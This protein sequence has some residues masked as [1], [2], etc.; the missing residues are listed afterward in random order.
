MSIESV[1]KQI[2][3]RNDITAFDKQ[4]YNACLK[5]PKGKVATYAYI[6]NAIKKPKAFRA[7]GSSLRRNPLAPAVPCHRVVSSSRTLGGFYGSTDPQGELLNKKLS[8]LVEEGVKIENNNTNDN[9]GSSGRRSKK[10]NQEGN[11]NLSNVKVQI[12]CIL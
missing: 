9:T 8:M 7:V 11:N 10:N 4:V 2:S 1:E 5:I 3:S 12:S 6:A